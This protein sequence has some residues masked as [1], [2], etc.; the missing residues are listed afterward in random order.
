M[1]LGDQLIGAGLAKGAAAKGK[2]IAFGDGKRILWDANSP[3]IWRGN[4]NIANPKATAMNVNT[5]LQM[6]WIPF[7]KGNRL[8]N[9]HAP[10]HW[11]WNYDF[12]CTPGEIY[13]TKEE[14]QYARMAGQDFILIEPN[15]S[16]KSPVANKQWPMERY[17]TVARTLRGHGHD[18]LQLNYR[19][20]KLLK[21]VRVF[22]C[23]NFRIA[24]A[25][26]ERAKL[27]IGGEGG[28]HHGAAAVGVPG[29]VLFGGFIPPSVTGYEMHTNLTG[30]AEACGSLNPCPHCAAAMQAIGADEVLEHAMARLCPP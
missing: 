23:H 20:A 25:I 17:E 2:I 6:E 5:H 24:L 8:Y 11:I 14:K 4:P 7:Y 12:H 26:M 21:S 22:P 16:P 9:K 28:L 27:F 1:G 15:P 18:V 10:G 3:V 30:G 19:G 29:V 13:L